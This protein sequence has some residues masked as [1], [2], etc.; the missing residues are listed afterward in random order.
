M[1]RRA[2]LFLTLVLA[3]AAFVARDSAA[4][5][6]DLV[7][8]TTE[9]TYDLRTDDGPVDVIWQ[10]RVRN[11][12]P[13]TAPGGNG[14]S[15]AF[16]SHIS[17]PVLRG[18]ESITALDSTGD[19]LDVAVDQS[20]T[21]SVV[22][23]RVDFAERLFYQDEYAFGFRYE[24][25]ETREQSV[26]VTPAYVFLPIVASGDESTVTVITPEGGEWESLI[27]AQDCEQDGTTFRCS[28]SDSAYI[29]ATAEASKPGARST[30]PLTAEV[31]G[32]TIDVN[33]TYFQ[34][35]ESAANHLR[36][37]IPAALPVI[38]SLFGFAYDGPATVNVEQGGREAVLGYEGI[39]QCSADSC[40]IIISPVADDITVIHELAHLWTD[41]YTERW[42]QEGFAQLIADEAAAAL[43][44]E[45]IQNRPLPRQ[46]E[47]VDLQLDDWGEV[48]S[49]IGAAAEQIAV[50]NAGYVLSLRFLEMLRLEAGNSV[51][52]DVNIAIAESGEPAD[53]RRYMDLIEDKS[54]LNLDQLFG[55]WVF[56]DAEQPLL[57]LRRQARD[58]LAEL[59]V[60]VQA[61]GLPEAATTGVREDI[62]AW[63][64]ESA[65]RKLDSVEGDIANYDDLVTKLTQIE[66]EASSLGLTLHAGMREALDRWEFGEVRLALADARDAIDAFRAARA[67]VYSSRSLWERFGLLG[68]DPEDQLDQA[69]REFASGS[70]QTSIDSSRAAEHTIDNA[71]TVALR[72]VLIVTGIFAVFGLIILAA[73]YASH[74]RDR[75]LAD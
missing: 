60:R 57:E 59:E 30:L 34:G 21:A 52:R 43:P 16:Y 61:E 19:Q 39:T 70:F 55:P 11:D 15:V 46:A 75:R 17:L 8:V 23:A 5:E 48:T 12:D 35:E 9:I 38:E 45:L 49:V 25:P 41:I 6:G 22:S 32:R 26:L 13:D 14:G 51:L 44:A 47:A 18:A 66:E 53:T 36:A 28:G 68:S 42:L 67:A 27:E 73:V 72:R 58:R 10:V 65:F 64:F 71:T 54:G 74:L 37:L 4:Q 50:E 33:L 7:H 1:L 40:Q 2:L 3:A 62:L 24:I 31:G 20:S 69:A 29:A 63:D 56:S